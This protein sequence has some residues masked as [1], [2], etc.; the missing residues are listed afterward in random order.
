M[1]WVW[2]NNTSFAYTKQWGLSTDIPVGLDFDGDFLTDL[3]VWRPSDGTWHWTFSSNWT[4]S[5]T[6]WGLRGD[7]PIG[8]PPS[9]L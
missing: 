1:W 2:Y 6:Q 4:N 3:T 5:S 7:V 8:I 9:M